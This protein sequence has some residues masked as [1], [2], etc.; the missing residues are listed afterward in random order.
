MLGGVTRIEQQAGVSGVEPWIGP[1]RLCTLS[2][3]SS[4]RCRFARSSFASY[5]HVPWRWRDFGSAHRVCCAN[6]VRR[7]QDKA[8]GVLL[9]PATTTRLPRDGTTRLLKISPYGVDLHP[10]P[11]GRGGRDVSR[12][13]FTLR[14][15]Q[16]FDRAFQRWV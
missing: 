2:E 11:V 7:E 4:E 16:V 8:V 12:P 15:A 6:D 9:C 1:F 14:F 10:E 13:V 5:D 3:S